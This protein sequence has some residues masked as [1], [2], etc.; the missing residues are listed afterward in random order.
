MLLRNDVVADR[1]A[2][3]GAL[4]GR[5]GGE[6]RLEQLVSDLRGDAGAIVANPDLDGIFG[7][8]GRHGEDGTERPVAILFGAL[9]GGVKA[10]AKEVEKDAGD[11]LRGQ[12]DRFEARRVIAFEGDVEVLVLRAP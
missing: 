12:F 9:V 11:L 8:A 10:V 4:A 1:E 7:L 6:E 2:K 5:L 3:A